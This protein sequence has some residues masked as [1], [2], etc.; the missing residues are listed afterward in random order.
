MEQ[1][2]AN[3]RQSLDAWVQGRASL[4]EI[5]SLAA[6]IGNHR[7][8][9]GVSTLLQLLDHEDEIVR[10]NAAMALGFD[11]NHKPATNKLLAM[12][13]EDADEDVRDVAAGA[14]RTLWQDTKDLQVLEGLAKAALTDADEGVRRAAYKAMLV[15]DGIPREQHLHLLTNASLPVDTAR[16][17]A[18][19][20]SIREHDPHA[21]RRLSAESKDGR[22]DF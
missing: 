2:N 1:T 13:A 18:I 21:I 12:L 7:Y 10:Y 3:L 4:A 20:S 5:R 16:V 19:L 17:W 11:L 8:A 14:L 15:V 9:P 6:D 22:R